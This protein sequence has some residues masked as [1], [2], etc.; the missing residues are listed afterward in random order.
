MRS[1]YSRIPSGVGVKTIRRVPIMDTIAS[2]G[3]TSIGSTCT[4]V[5]G[6][7]GAGGGGMAMD[8]SSCCC[9]SSITL[10]G[11]VLGIVDSAVGGGLYD[12]TARAFRSLVLSVCTT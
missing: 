6:G 4:S 12:F 11:E 3:G 10:V 2:V 9:R 8:I 7:K 5:G 1:E